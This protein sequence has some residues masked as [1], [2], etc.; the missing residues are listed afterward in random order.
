LRNKSGEIEEL[1]DSFRREEFLQFR[2][3]GSICRTSGICHFCWRNRFRVQLGQG[4]NHDEKRRKALLEEIE[5]MHARPEIREILIAA[6]LKRWALIGQHPHAYP[7]CS[8]ARAR[9]NF[10]K[11]LSRYPQIAQRFGMTIVS[12]YPPI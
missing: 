9:R 1:S 7:N 4:L 2:Q 12:A 8:P 5:K 10:S 6:K 11:L 3:A